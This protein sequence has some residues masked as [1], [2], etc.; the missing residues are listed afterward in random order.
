MADFGYIQI[1]R[2]CNQ[3]CLFCSNPSTGDVLSL[4]K[5]KKIIS[6]YRKNELAGVILTG[7][8]P[9]MHPDLL[10]IVRYCKENKVEC[11]IVTNGQRL[12]YPQY[13]KALIAAGL[14][15]LHISIYSNKKNVQDKLT[16]NDG[17]LVN[18]EKAF[19]NLAGHPEVSVNVNVTINRQ[20]QDH[21]KQVAEWVMD[22]YPH[23][24][25]FVF[26]N[27]DPRSSVIRNH[28][29]VIPRLADLKRS[30]RE[31]LR[32]LK[33]KHITFRV[34]RV[35]LCYMAEFAYASTETRK[36]VKMEK[37]S[38]FFLDKKGSK[39]QEDF[40]RLKGGLCKKCS[41][42]K[43]CAGVDGDGKCYN[44][45]DLKPVKLNEESIRKIINKIK[46]ES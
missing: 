11:K 39:I 3:K 33:S 19:N 5:I 32:F 23:K 22:N 10:E 31:A 14:R 34:E 30:L 16:Q 42:D 15:Q 37:R 20:N 1:I 40:K 8:E 36:I 21:L 28:P 45:S 9:T 26:N 7:G 18:L 38:M 2:V 44:V 25:H 4:E 13:L 6:R 46:K 41:L 29:E 24:L 17:A 43:I 12:A 35:P 27:L